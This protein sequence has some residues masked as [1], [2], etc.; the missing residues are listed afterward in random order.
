MIHARTARVAAILLAVLIGVALPSACTATAHAEAP[1]GRASTGP[2]LTVPAKLLTASLTCTS[3]VRRAAQTPVL[4]IHGTGATSDANWA[5]SWVPALD[6]LRRPHC[7]VQ[8]PSFGNTDVQVSAEYVVHALRTMNRLAGRQVSIVGHS[9]GGMIGRWALKYWP[10]TRAMVDDFVG[11]APSNHGTDLFV[12]Q[13]ALPQG[14]SPAQWQQRTGSRFLE[15]LNAGR[16][17]WPGI[18]YTTIITETDEVILPPRAGYLPRQRGGGA[19]ANLS[20]QQLCPTETVEHF[21]MAYDNAAWL[22]GRDALSHAGTARLD[23][24][25]RSTCGDP[26]LPNADVVGLATGLTDIAAG[27]AGAPSVLKEPSLRTYARQ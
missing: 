23:R 6:H 14:C 19:V 10:D 4:L 9:Q 21:G 20:V 13:C 11:L 5:S 2:R 12:V 18:D 3:S 24:V 27:I 25:D 17:T 8:L 1:Q 26:F 7:E 22:L 16:Q 15:A